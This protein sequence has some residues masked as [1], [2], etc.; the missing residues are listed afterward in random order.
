MLGII[1]EGDPLM[2][3]RIGVP[4]LRFLRESNP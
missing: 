3:D 1:E 2:V 4:D